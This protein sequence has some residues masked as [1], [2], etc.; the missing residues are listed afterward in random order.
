MSLTEAKFTVEWMERMEN[1][2]FQYGYKIPNQ[3]VIDLQNEL[4]NKYGKKS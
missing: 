1:L 3:E 4:N 2:H